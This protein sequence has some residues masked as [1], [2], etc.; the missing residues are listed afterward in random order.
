MPQGCTVLDQ[1]T[2]SGDILR[3][4]LTLDADYYIDWTTGSCRFDQGECA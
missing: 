2:T 1:F 3:D 4:V